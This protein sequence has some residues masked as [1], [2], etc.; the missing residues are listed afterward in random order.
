MLR[1]RTAVLAAAALAGAGAGVGGYAAVAGGQGTTPAVG[2]SAV[3]NTASTTNGLGVNQIYKA[4]C[5]GVVEIATT[6]TSS[7]NTTPSPFGNGG[8]SQQSQRRGPAFPDARERQGR[9]DRERHQ[10]LAG[11]GRR[12]TAGDVITALDRPTITTPDN[13]TSA[14][15]AKQAG[16]KAP[17]TY[18][19]NGQT[20]TTGVTLASRS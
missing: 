1:K 11:R 3:A 7:P 8:G 5:K 17:V 15:S 4:D 20:D 14:V 9:R 2:Q 18:V 16:A 12:L 6:G 10:R 13:L 19:R